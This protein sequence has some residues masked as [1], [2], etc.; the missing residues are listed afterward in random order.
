MKRFKDLSL[1]KKIAATSIV[2]IILLV[3][4]VALFIIPIVEKNVMNER[5]VN[6]KNVIDLASGI[7]AKFE[8]QAT[9]GEMTREEAMEKAQA[10]IKS[11]RYGVGQKEYLWINDT[12]TPY[13]KMIMHPIAPTL[14]GTVMDDPKYN[15]AMGKNQNLFQAM[16]GVTKTG[17]GG[18]GFVDYLWPKPGSDKP[19][20]K[21]SYVKLYEPWNWIVG[22]GVYIDDVATIVHKMQYTIYAVI[23]GT[24]LLS[25]IM[26]FFIARI[27]SNSLGQG[28]E[29]AGSVA[30]GDMTRTLDI[31]QE[32]EVGR[33]AGSLNTMVAKLG[34]MF[35]DMVKNSEILSAA[36][37]KFSAL[38]DQLAS[39][40]SDT[41]D[42]V[43]S[44][45][46]AVEEMNASVTS[47]SASSEQSLM[48]VD[49]VSTAA[50]EMTTTIGEISKNTDQ[51]NKTTK[52]A[53]EDV[54]KTLETINQ[55]GDA[56]DEIEKVTDTIYE[57]SEQT[58]LLAL[59]ATIEAARAG[60]AGKGFAVVA[61]EIK[62]LATQTT[63]ATGEIDR[64]VKAIQSSTRDAVEK[65]NDIST[66]IHDLND[67]VSVV[68][69]SLREQSAN[70]EEIVNSV[71]QVHQ[72]IQ[73]TNQN[74]AQLVESSNNISSDIS[75]VSNST[76]KA[77]DTS[78]QINSSAGDLSQMAASLD[79]ALHRFKF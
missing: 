79:R 15:C 29:F 51:A 58:N 16:V 55:L 38:S 35:S 66:V 78:Q 52:Q 17:T 76:D 72:G 40:S 22:S 10:C 49:V 70:T 21:L 8:A 50:R 6:L 12:G 56:A 67:V 39:A 7:M 11:L 57:I 65:I 42:Q 19:V 14:D 5:Q 26:T 71:A 30:N 23:L 77:F 64:R 20:E 36:S 41:N 53:V 69:S 24:V 68:T 2:T 46:A 75:N 61:A 31:D 3:I 13:P 43:I 18:G 34:E 27:I 54:A 59:N 9:Q 45:T 1:F 25:L 32:D 37:T 4:A 62:D 63:N 73:E 44:I 33:L 60:E 48:G 28:I 74:L 47:I